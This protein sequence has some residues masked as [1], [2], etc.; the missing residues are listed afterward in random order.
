MRN[1]FLVFQFLCFVQVSKSQSYQQLKQH[2]DTFN[3]CIELIY[4]TSPWDRETKTPLKGI[5]LFEPGISMSST[6]I[7]DSLNT[8]A[9]SK[10]EEIITLPGFIQYRVDTLLNARSLFSPDG[11][12]TLYS[13]YTN[14]GGTYKINQTI[15]WSVPE[16]SLN[17]LAWVLQNIRCAVELVSHKN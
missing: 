17:S 9:R 15:S 13:W 12:I 16:K 10:I 1:Y 3:R 6:L 7:I 5:L 11:K 14:N 2:A 4:K 8:M